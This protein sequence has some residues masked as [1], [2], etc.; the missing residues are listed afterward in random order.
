MQEQPGPGRPNPIFVPDLAE[1]IPDTV[2]LQVFRHKIG[3]V[4]F[5][6][7]LIESNLAGVSFLLDPEVAEPY[8]PHTATAF[9]GCDR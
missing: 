6:T 3:R 2:S 7:D 1:Q 9:A 5:P 4:A 8:V